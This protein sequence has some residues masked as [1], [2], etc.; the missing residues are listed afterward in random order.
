MDARERPAI[1]L[2]R[3]KKKRGPKAPSVILLYACSTATDDFLLEVEDIASREDGIVTAGDRRKVVTV[4]AGAAGGA[5]GCRT[6]VTH[7]GIVEINKRGLA[8]DVI[9]TDR[10]HVTAAVSGILQLV[11]IKP[12]E[13][14]LV[15]AHFHRRDQTHRITVSSRDATKVAQRFPQQAQHDVVEGVAARQADA[16]RIVGRGVPVPDPVPS[17]GHSTAADSRARLA[18]CLVS[19]GLSPR[20]PSS[21]LRDTVG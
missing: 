16:G 3:P 2:P 17:A 19:W 13:L 6:V 8:E 20:L 18:A 7:G 15:V 21:P 1:R 12:M 4:A 14:E 9:H 11:G 5:E 10:K